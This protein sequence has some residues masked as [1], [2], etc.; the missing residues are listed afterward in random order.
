[1]LGGR[2]AGFVARQIIE[3]ANYR[4]LPRLLRVSVRPLSFARSYFLGGGV[5][6]SPCPLRTP[7]GVVAPTMYS[8]HDV[9]TV[10]EVFCRDDYRLP[11]GARVVLDIGSNIG[12]SALYFLTRSPEVRVH[13]YEPDPR[14]AER[15]RGNLAAFDGRWTLHEEAVGDRDG[16]VAF[17][18]DA[19]GRYGGIG[20]ATAEQIQVRCRHID[21]VLREVL[22]LEGHIDFVKID[23]EGLENATVAAI[24]RT[25]LAQLGGLCY[26]TR[27]PLNPWPE[28]F[29]MRVRADTCRLIAREH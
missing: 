28:R 23:T 12:I 22:A 20:V 19:T 5:F 14:N 15:L 1:M 16:A 17:G 2:S 26:E 18:R 6:P 9:F 8:H 3:P 11:S 29:T 7:M 24:D 10:N 25:L 21:D 27:S 13:L 4:S